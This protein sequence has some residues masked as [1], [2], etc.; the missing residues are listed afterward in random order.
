VA[1]L[2]CSSLSIASV[3]Q[4]YDWPQF[5]GGPRHSGDNTLEHVLAAGNVGKLNLLFKVNLP[6]T[7]D[8]AVTILSHVKTP[9]GTVDVLFAT[10]KAGHLLALNAHSGATIWTRQVGPGT[11]HFF[12]QPLSCF[13]NSSPAIDPNRRFVYSYGLDGRVHKYRVGDGAEVIGQGWPEVTTL[14]LNNEKASSALSVARTISGDRYL[15]V[16][17]AGTGPDVGTYQGHLTTINLATGAQHV[18]NTMCSNHVDEHYQG[19]LRTATCPQNFGGIWGRS[20]VVYDRDTNR[21]YL[22]V[23][24]GAFD[25]DKHEWGDSVLALNPDGTGRAN[26]DPLDSY[27]PRNYADLLTFDFDLGSSSPVILPVGPQSRI[28]HLALQAGKDGKLRL[29]NLS[30]MGGQG[31]PGHLGSEVSPIIDV[32]QSGPVLTVPATW[33]NPADGSTWVYVANFSG[34]AGLRLLFN[35]HGT[36]YLHPV[37]TRRDGGSSPLVANGVVYEAGN[38]RMQALDPLTGKR[39]WQDTGLHNIH[40]ASPVVANGI[41]YISDWQ[42]NQFSRLLA[43]SL[44]GL[45]AD[46]QS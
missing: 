22:A 2:L 16:V 6:S 39:L 12:D 9:S 19:P 43:Y 8:G 20:G 17:H 23:G 24:N 7:V 33:V 38:N 30:N 5:N 14:R 4:P 46:S 42:D 45:A 37:W 11:C 26:G 21:I 15:Y 34:I 25:P 10:T 18:F 31:G 41:L 13:T 40:W 44:P 36:P 27:T 28:K 32:P 3:P 35:S 1:T 29:I